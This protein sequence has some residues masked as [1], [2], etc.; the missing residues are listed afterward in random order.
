MFINIVLN[1]IVS[2]QIFFLE[3][4]WVYLSVYMQ[5]YHVALK[6]KTL[7]LQAVT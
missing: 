7:T 3:I 5:M 6:L 4:D 1:N 2:I